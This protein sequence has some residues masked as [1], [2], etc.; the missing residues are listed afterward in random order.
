MTDGVLDAGTDETTMPAT[1]WRG[2]SAVDGGT[3]TTRAGADPSTPAYDGQPRVTEASTASREEQPSRYRYLIAV[4]MDIET[5]VTIDQLADAMAEWEAAHDAAEKSWHDVH[6]E[7]YLVDLPT[8]DNVG[9][10]EFDADAG[11]VAR[12]DHQ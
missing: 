10:L 11:I 4:V 6:E 1:R 7:L 8:L 12:P 3:M 2:R 9:V 5:T